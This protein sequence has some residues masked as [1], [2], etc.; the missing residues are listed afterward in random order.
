MASC[1][2]IGCPNIVREKNLRGAPDWVIEVLLPATAKKDEGVKRDLY[3]RAGV[4]EYWLVHPI[5][6]S[7]TRYRLLRGSYGL[8]DVFG[9]GDLVWCPFPMVRCWIWGRSLPN[10]RFYSC[11]ATRKHL[12]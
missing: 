4:K 3:Q 11:C 1:D 10:F 9:S 8:P 6:H 7:L 5:D 12:A 2:D